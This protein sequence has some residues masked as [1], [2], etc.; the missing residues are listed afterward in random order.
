MRVSTLTEKLHSYTV[1]STYTESWSNLSPYP[2]HTAPS[3][4][5]PVANSGVLVSLNP[6]NTPCVANARTTAGAPMALSARYCSAGSCMGEERE[7]PMTERTGEA[8]EDRK[9]AS[10]A[11]RPRATSREAE[12]EGRTGLEKD[13]RVRESSG[14]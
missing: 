4:P 3:L 12:T 13:L 7:T 14:W 6:R 11:P 8:A 9:R 2:H 1:C 5:L 10:S